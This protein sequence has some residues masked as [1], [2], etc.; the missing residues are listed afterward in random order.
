MK[1]IKTQILWFLTATLFAACGSDDNAKPDTEKGKIDINQSI[2]FRVNLADY[3]SD[4]EVLSRNANNQNVDTLRPKAIDLGNGI[5]AQMTIQRDTA[6][7]NQLATTR[8]LENGT[9]TML[10]YQG[11][12]LKG[13]QTGTVIYGMFRVTSQSPGGFHGMR[14]EPGTYDFVLFNDKVTRS[15][16]NLTVRK[17]NAATALIGRT[18]ATVNSTQN[19]QEIAFQMKH[20][21]SRVRFKLTGFT[22]LTNLTGNFWSNNYTPTSSVYNISTGTWTVATTEGTSMPYTFSAT[23][24]VDENNMYNG[25]TDYQYYLPAIDKSDMHYQFKGKIYNQ[26]FQFSKILSSSEY[27]TL[28]LDPNSSYLVTIKLTY[29][30]LYLMTNGDIGTYKDTYFGGGTNTPIA[31]VVSRARF[32]AVALKDVSYKAAWCNNVHN[33]TM[34]QL[35]TYTAQG[36]VGAGFTVLQTSGYSET[37]DAS[38]STN[39][40]VGNKVKGL[41]PDFPA[42][43]AAAHFNPGIGYTGS[44]ALQWYLASFSDWKWAFSTLGLGDHTQIKSTGDYNWYQTLAHAAFTQVGG[45]AFKLNNIYMTSTEYGG[46]GFGEL[47][48]SDGSI[49]WYQQMKLLVPYPTGYVRPFVK[50]K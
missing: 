40:V 31:V 14:L 49:G 25:T 34:K 4:K 3:N 11:G 15:G 7:T 23:T 5:L 10:A 46:F 35:N 28:A 18:T 12:V 2:E 9:Y 1:T 47:L 22:P 27:N 29:A 48:M 26:N 17:E 8:A 37:W 16:S 41:N 24:T 32:M 44:P 33:Y 42:F 6:K 39:A 38:H 36:A 19:V 50:Y 21:A 30:F 45:T 13:E 43:Y 20:A